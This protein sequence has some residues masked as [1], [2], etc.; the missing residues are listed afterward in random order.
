MMPVLGYTLIYILFLFIA[1]FIIFNNT[2]ETD[3]EQLYLEIILIG[4][5]GFVIGVLYAI[6]K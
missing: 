3:R 2:T 4:V 6:I 1:V 5:V